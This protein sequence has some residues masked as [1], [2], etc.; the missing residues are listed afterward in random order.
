MIA[1][2]RATALADRLADKG[3]AACAACRPALRDHPGARPAPTNRRRR[4]TPRSRRRRSNRCGRSSSPPASPRASG[5]QHPRRV[6]PRRDQ[7]AVADPHL[8]VHEG[9]R[10][11]DQAEQVLVAARAHLPVLERYDAALYAELLGIAEGAEVTPEAIV[12]ANHYTD[13]RD[14]DPDPAKWKPAPERD[15]PR[16]LLADLR[17]DLRT[18]RVLAQTWD[19]HATAI[20]YVME[21]FS[22]TPDATLLSVTGC[23]R[24]GR[25]EQ[26]AHRHRDQQPVLDRRDARR[27]VAG[28]GAASVA[29]D[30]GRARQGRRAQQPDRLGASLLRRRQGPRIR[31]RGVGK[32]TAPRLRPRPGPRLRGAGALRPHQPAAPSTR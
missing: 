10:V 31:H 13:L 3:V 20:P 8:P 30:L 24:H 32:A 2:E 22:V 29:R 4:L 26:R 21:S 5:G 11:R 18:G 17:G 1:G 9:R 16:R 23:S 7:G 28:D 14:L 15:R 25:D 27:G 6:V 12:V 19:M